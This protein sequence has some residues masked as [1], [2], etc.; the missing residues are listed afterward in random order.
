VV[1]QISNFSTT[2]QHTF[3]PVVAWSVVARENQKTSNRASAA[4]SIVAQSHF[5]LGKRSPASDAVQM[6][7]GMKTTK[8]A[9]C[10]DSVG[11]VVTFTV[12]TGGQ[13]RGMVVTS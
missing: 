3:Q 13:R 1:A 9:L 6:K 10:S 4:D 7:A 5:G 11:M 12:H 8:V 2:G